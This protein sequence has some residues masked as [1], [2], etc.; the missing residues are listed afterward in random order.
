MKIFKFHLVLFIIGFCGQQCFAQDPTPDVINAKPGSKLVASIDQKTAEL[1]VRGCDDIADSIIL[2]NSEDTFRPAIKLAEKLEP[3][4]PELDPN[5]REGFCHY[6]SMEIATISVSTGGIGSAGDELFALTGDI[7]PAIE[8]ADISVYVREG[9]DLSDKGAFAE[10]SLSWTDSETDQIVLRLNRW[11]LGFKLYSFGAT[12]LTSE[13]GELTMD[14]ADLNIQMFGDA[15]V[16]L[17]GPVYLAGN[18]S[19]I[20]SY[21]WQNGSKNWNAGHWDIS[22]FE[23]LRLEIRRDG[24]YPIAVARFEL[25]GSDLFRMQFELYGEAGWEYRGFSIKLQDPNLTAVVNLR[26][27]DWEVLQ[28]SIAGSF[29]TQLPVKGK[30]GFSMQWQR[31]AGLGKG[32]FVMEISSESDIQ[33]FGVT[34][35]ELALRVELDPDALTFNE[36]RGS[37]AFQHESFDKPIVIRP[38]IIRDG[39]LKKFSGSGSVS[40]QKTFKLDVSKLYYDAE[41][42]PAMLEVNAQLDFGWSKAGTGAVK[43]E[44]FKIYEDGKISSFNI[45]GVMNAS[46]VNLAFKADYDADL[47]RFKGRFKGDLGGAIEMGG[48]V[49]IGVMQSGK[50]YSYGCLGIVFRS[51]RGIPI[52]QSGLMLLGL[53]GAIGANASPPMS[54]IDCEKATPELGRFYLAGGLTVG[55]AGGLA[56]LSGT[57]SLS[58]G[59]NSMIGIKGEVEVTRRTRYFGGEV[60]ANYDLGSDR[61]FGEVSASVNVPANGA[62]ISISKNRLKYA[63]ENNK[64][65]IDGVNLRGTFFNFLEVSGGVITLQGGLSDPV[66][67]M[68]GRMSARLNGGTRIVWTHPDGFTPYGDGSGGSCSV[69]N[70]GGLSLDCNC[71]GDGWAIG[72]GLLANLSGQ[73]NARLNR[74]GTEGNF[75]LRTSLSGTAAIQRPVLWG[76]ACPWAKS[77]NLSGVLTGRNS[78]G[79]LHVEGDLTVATGFGIDVDFGFSHDF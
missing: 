2:G 74:Y 65:R 79:L 31:R 27:N 77:V 11:K 42:T 17:H 9:S 36:I 73:I 24:I 14:A 70:T 71:S 16:H 10:V 54:S 49:L 35:T 53:H 63:M 64:Y 41:V 20:I 29:T 43:V 6:E 40:F 32:L 22:A 48:S 13:D 3:L 76:E 26:T 46:P 55:D 28:G 18:T 78:N 12:F 45:D 44:N 66:R 69:F 1:E 7:L 5:S 75:S 58:L 8:S 15:N 25:V 39:S 57:V 67:T 47:V 4:D 21:S 52:G 60:S 33:A 68:T 34:C 19:G 37:L 62:V 61:V 50:P 59:T 51:D 23:G 56:A 72:G 30:F 38:F